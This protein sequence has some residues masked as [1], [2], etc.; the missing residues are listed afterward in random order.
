MNKKH[1]LLSRFAWTCFLLLIVLVG[2]QI[3]IPGIDPLT[4]GR[5]LDQVNFLQFISMTTGG[6]TAVPSLLTLGM[7]PYMTMMIIWQVIT[8]LDL[9]VVK[10]L[11]QRRV[12]I[13]Q[14]FLTL[15]FSLIQGFE[16]IYFIRDAFDSNDPWQIG[17]NLNVA[18]AWIVLVGG[19]MFM[20]WLGDFNAVHGIGGTIALIIPGI[21][22]SIP[23]G[24]SSGVGSAI[25]T[26]YSLTTQH[27]IIAVLIGL[28]FIIVMYYLYQG[29]LHLHV[30]RPLTP[31]VYASSY[32]PMRF[33]TAGAMPFMFSSSLFSV[34]RL[35]VNQTVGPT[36][37]FQRWVA[38]WFSFQTWQGILMYGILIV[39]L[40]YAFG[41]LNVQPTNVAK[42]MKE[43]G[44]YFLNVMPGDPTEM[45]LSGHFGRLSLLGNLILALI[46]V[47][48][49]IVGLYIP[50]TANFSVLFSSLFILIT[51]T[52]TII[53]QVRALRTK[54][55]YS[56]F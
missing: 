55:R 34:P 48:P 45:F 56:V 23:T 25:T 42:E 17:I 9:D 22:A 8:A 24:L 26:S 28:L 16:M 38:T 19:A 12:G 49:L 4:A 1:D 18:I 36:D 13:I 53:Q 6:Q 5:S 29:E 39:L 54:D 37:A 15:F 7:R 27:I 2:Q 32:F 3:L 46:G 50:G 14:R 40:G 21:I 31:S 43:N 51:L 11:S 41:Y 20:T 52:D 47:G 10:Q 44:E 33:L 35:L 30:E